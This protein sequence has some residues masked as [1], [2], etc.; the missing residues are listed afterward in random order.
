MEKQKPF[1][2]LAFKIIG[3]LILL[4]A[5]AGLLSW[6]WRF[7]QPLW[8]ELGLNWLWPERFWYSLLL[9]S[10]LAALAGGTFWFYQ[11]RSRPRGAMP[12][13]ETAWTMARDQVEEKAWQRYLEVMTG[14][15][16]EKGL[17]TAAADSEVRT[18]ARA[19]TL[20]ILREL[21]DR[22]KGRVL[23][24]L[25]EAGLIKRKNPV[26]HLQGA[27]LNW[28][29]LNW[30]ELAGANLGGVDLRG[31]GLVGADLPGANLIGADLTGANLAAADLG[32]ADLRGA[33]LKRAD[34]REAMLPWADLREADLE[35]ADLRRASL[36]RADLR[37][38]DLHGANLGKADL[39]GAMLSQT[40]LKGA[41][42]HE[43]IMPDGRKKGLFRGLNRF[44][45]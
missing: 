41:A 2:R 10:L 39:A 19:R 11:A 15:L 45:N 36:E 37:G 22:R 18:V 14:L 28:A 32:W 5:L 43:A 13:A 42:L 40:N 24:F 25:Y 12:Q 17:R 9:A 35:W 34:L 16:L 26:V 38:A 8:A 3:W 20:A 6:A 27:D 33:C 31:A 1:V 44:T 30:A 7:S 29:D 21:H 23:R 4:M